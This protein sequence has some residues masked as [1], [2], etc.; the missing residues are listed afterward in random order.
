[1]KKNFFQKKSRIICLSW[2]LIGIILLCFVFIASYK[3]SSLQK[4]I[5]KIVICYVF[6]SCITSGIVAYLNKKEKKKE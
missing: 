4:I 3:D 6:A 2:S 1:M 5:G